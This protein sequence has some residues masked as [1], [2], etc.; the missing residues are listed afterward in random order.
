MPNAYAT[1]SRTARAVLEQQRRLKAGVDAIELLRVIPQ[2][3]Q[4]E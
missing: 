2:A 3:A 1:I 4:K